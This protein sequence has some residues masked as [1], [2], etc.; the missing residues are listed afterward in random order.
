VSAARRNRLIL[1]CGVISAILAAL[2]LN[3]C[4]SS[5]A[6][7]RTGPAASASPRPSA[8]PSASPS[9][10]PV[11][12]AP[13]A[14]TAGSYQVGQQEMTFT[15]PAHSGPTGQALP[16]R[17]LITTIQYPL[18]Q[19]SATQPPRGP[20]PLIL[21]APGYQQCASAYGDLLQTWASAGYIVAAVTFP[22]TNCQL[23]KKTADEN[24][25]VN[26]PQDM[27][28][29]LSSL[30]ALSAQP[31]GLLSGLVN[32]QEIA[33][34]GQSDG[35]DTVAALV[36]N[37]CCTD[38]RV[39]AAAVLS[40]AEWPA[41]PGQY[42][43][44]STP[45]ILFTQGNADNV[46]P[47]AASVALYRGDMAGPRYYLNLLG[48]S[49]LSPYEARTA[50]EQVVVRVT[51]AFFNGYVL[52]QAGAP[53]AISQAGNVGGTSALGSGGHVPRHAG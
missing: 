46:N 14:G 16:P 29:V 15:E 49:H 45:P 37:T 25:L 22:Q 26:Q 18:A 33:A 35:G 5:S 42:F 4:T 13:P 6:S 24:D 21:F 40:G 28:F 50:A 27:S 47:P 23:S 2:I 1:T 52:D 7:P 8:S 32:R 11:P 9:P 53:A 17:S 44:H 10:S 12:T 51:L 34:A 31:S 3:A 43:T 19:G 38:T 20:F 36:G 41:M 48:A 39:R 30:L